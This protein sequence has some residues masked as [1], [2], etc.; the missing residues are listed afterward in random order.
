MTPGLPGYVVHD[1][2]WSVVSSGDDGHRRP[3]DGREPAVARARDRGEAQHL[4][5]RRHRAGMR[6]VAER[7]VLED[8][9]R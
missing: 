9:R 6:V 2:G 8:R 7:E 4:A 5:A 3:R 1:A